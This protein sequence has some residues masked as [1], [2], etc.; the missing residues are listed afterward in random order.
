V[1]TL[2]DAIGAAQIRQTVTGTDEEVRQV[3]AASVQLVAHART[4]YNQPADKQFTLTVPADH[5]LRPLFEKAEAE[6]GQHG[7]L[8]DWTLHQYWM[9]KKPGHFVAGFVPEKDAEELGVAI[10][11]AAGPDGTHETIWVGNLNFS[12]VDDL[13][14]QE[15]RTLAAELLEAADECDRCAKLRPGQCLSVES[16]TGTDC[17]LDNGD[18]HNIHF[19]ADGR[20]FWGHP[21]DID[22]MVPVAEAGAK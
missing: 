19:S 13:T 18:G 2:Q 20:R 1:S 10:S 21:H 8:L 5:H 11:P 7:I 22:A 6:L 9:V 3:I 16:S 17:H 4:V 14:A 12:P 15:M